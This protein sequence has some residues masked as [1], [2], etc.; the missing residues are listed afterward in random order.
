MDGGNSALNATPFPIKTQIE[1]QP[2]YAQNQFGLTF[3]GQPYVPHVIE[4]DTKDVIFFNLTGQRSSSPFSEYGSVPT[5]LE[6]DGD[7]SG[8]TT[9]EGAPI[10]IY[11]PVTKAPFPNNIIPADRIVTQATALFNYIPVPSLPGQFQN[12]QRLTSSESNNT[13]IGVRF[14][15]S[16]GSSSGGSPI[17]G[18]IRQY[19]GQGGPGI[20]QSMNVNFNY[21][22]AGG[23][24]TESSSPTLAASSRPTSIRWRSATRWAKAG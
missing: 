2:S 23:R 10:T 21:S 12:Y 24:R 6:R 9:Q 17:G 4:H 1:P 16:F 20:R 5:A 13:R 11:D 7:L 22:H 19:T 18:L 8:L 14:L 3:M 15:H